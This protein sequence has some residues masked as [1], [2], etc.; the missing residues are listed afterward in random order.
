MSK[1]VKVPSSYSY[2]LVP[3]IDFKSVDRRLTRFSGL[4]TMSYNA[5]ESATAAYHSQSYY[6]YKLLLAN[7]AHL[8]GFICHYQYP[9]NNTIS[10]GFLK[11]DTKPF[12]TK[13]SVKV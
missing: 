4:S 8:R 5:L 12:E 7:V 9:Q 6:N 3:E 13:T 11:V 2:T 1:C 10:A